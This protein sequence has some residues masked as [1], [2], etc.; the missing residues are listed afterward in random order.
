MAVGFKLNWPDWDL[1]LLLAL[2]LA[3][4]TNCFGRGM[5]FNRLEALR[6]GDARLLIPSPSEAFA[7]FTALDLPYWEMLL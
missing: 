3:P 7:G 1:G 4:A 6:Y 2:L 5:F